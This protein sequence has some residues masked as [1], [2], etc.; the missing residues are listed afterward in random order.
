MHAAITEITR[1]LPF[2]AAS[3]AQR[4]RAVGD[5]VS[6]AAVLILPQIKLNSR[7][8]HCAFFL[9]W[10]MRRIITYGSQNQGGGAGTQDSSPGEG[11]FSEDIS[12]REGRAAG[13]SDWL[14]WSWLSAGLTLSGY[15]KRCPGKSKVAKCEHPDQEL[16]SCRRPRQ[17]LRKTKL[18][19]PKVVF[20][21]K[22]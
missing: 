1:L 9:S 3:L 14:G 11:R 2:P 19:S 21:V 16:L 10:H 6:Q 15:F 17:Q 4:L 20:L 13:A 5:A 12:R 8:L 22:M 7:L 18:F